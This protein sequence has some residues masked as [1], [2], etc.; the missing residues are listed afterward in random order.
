M[1]TSSF[2]FTQNTEA[3]AISIQD[4]LETCVIEALGFASTLQ[5]GLRWE[6]IKSGPR[7]GN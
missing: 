1:N 7:R 4:A 6:S 2:L 5:Q 3:T